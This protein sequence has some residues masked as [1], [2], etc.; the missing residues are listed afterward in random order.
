MALRKIH[1]TRVGTKCAVRIYRNPE[2][3]EYVV[4]VIVN[5]RVQGGK[6]GGAFES[7]KSAARGTAAALVRRLRAQRSCR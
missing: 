1:E 4:K 3:D 7:D 2:F 5:G 6:E